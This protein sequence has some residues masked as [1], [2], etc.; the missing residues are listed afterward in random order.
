MQLVGSSLAHF[1]T[2]PGV[3]LGV[4]PPGQSPLSPKSALSLNFPH[5]PLPGHRFSASS[6]LLV[7]LGWLTV[8]LIPWLSEFHAVWFS[9]T[10]DC[11]LILDWLLSSF[12]LCEEAKG[13]YLY[14]HLGWNSFFFFKKFNREEWRWFSSFYILIFL[15]F[16][17][18]FLERGEGREK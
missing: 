14:L 9:G 17:Y 5:G 18:L 8:S 4:L 7:C 6:V 3:R 13:F 16:I 1:P 10:S 12:C 11:L 2:N 15:H